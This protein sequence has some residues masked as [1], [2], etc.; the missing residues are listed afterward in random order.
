MYLVTVVDEK[1]GI[2]K[3]NQLL[4]RLPLDMERFRKITS[5]S[6]DGKQ[7]IVIMDRKTFEALKK[8]LDGRI[9]IILTRDKK[10]KA[11]GCVVSNSLLELRYLIANKYYNHNVFVIGGAE[12][13][14]SLLPYCTTFFVTCIK[15]DYKADLKIP[16]LKG[17]LKNCD[18][19]EKKLYK[20][21]LGCDIQCEYV[22]Y[23]LK[24]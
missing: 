10:Y 1:Y 5:T 11:D 15:K 20:D 8:P 22:E 4:D 23:R 19:E 13:Y 17:V 9:N 3:D 6:K 14:S 24:C 16:K 21:G 7:N 18:I 12:V 2:S